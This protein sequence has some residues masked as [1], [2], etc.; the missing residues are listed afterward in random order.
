M[1]AI[2]SSSRDTEATTGMLLMIGAML[3]V[4]GLDTIAKL[5]VER[6]SPAQVGAGRLLA[7]SLILL[8]VVLIAGQWGAPGRLHALAGVFLGTALLCLNTA[9]IA[10]PVANA[11]AIFFVEPLILTLLGGLLLGERLGWRRL[12]AVAVGLAGA[13]VVLRPNLAAYGSA[14]LWPLATAVLFACYML[15]TRVMTRS[16][17]RLALQFWTGAFAALVLAG[18]AVG[19]ALFDPGGG[20]LLLPT[21]REALLF[22]AMGALA[23]VAHAM[24]VGAIARIEAGAVAPFQYLEIISAT[25]LGWL[26][27]GD[28]PDGMTWAG[29]TL[30]VAAGIYVFHRERRLAR[31]AAPARPR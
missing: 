12:S 23:A 4:P 11:I 30:I 14:A 19:A 8:P 21:G 28:F 27:F 1:S 31:E 22:A 25:L 2:P 7:Q 17:G 9:L 29:T 24:I 13:L 15:T 18:G 10:L 20:A 3:I 6:L 16:G 5:L 26:V